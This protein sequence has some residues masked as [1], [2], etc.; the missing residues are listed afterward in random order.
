METLAILLWVT[1]NIILVSFVGYTFGWW[2]PPSVV[3]ML[4]ILV[5]MAL[6]TLLYTICVRW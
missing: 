2:G 4:A 5:V 3:G 6:N 1:F